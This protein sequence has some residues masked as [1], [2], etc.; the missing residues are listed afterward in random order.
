MFEA[1]EPRRLLSVVPSL[2]EI[3]ISAAAKA[4][5]PTLNN[6]RCFDLDVTV[7]AGGEDWASGD[8]KAVLTNG[9]F[10]NVPAANPLD[11][12]VAQKSLW[13]VRP[14]LEFDTFVTAPNFQPRWK[15]GSDPILNRTILLGSYQ[16][17]SQ[18]PIFTDTQVNASWGD[19]TRTGAGTFTVA[20]LTI[21]KDA[22]G[23]AQGRV[24]NITQPNDPTYYDSILPL[25]PSNTPPVAN[26][27]SYDTAQDTV[28][29]ILPPGMLTNDT[30]AD[31]DALTAVLAAGP[32]Y[33]TL[34]FDEDGSFIYQPATGFSGTDTFTY[35]ASDGTDASQ[36][37]TVTINVAPAAAGTITSG[38]I[39]PTDPDG[40]KTLLIVNGG[41]DNDAIQIESADGGGVQVSVNGQ[42]DPTV[43]NPTGRIVIFGYGGN[44]SISVDGSVANPVWAY[45]DDGNDTLNLGN[46]GG[47]AFGGA[48]GDTLLGGSAR[49]IL[50]GGLG[51]DRI[52]GNAGDDILISGYTAFDTRVGDRAGTAP[53]NA[54]ATLEHEPAWSSIAAES[55]SGHEYQ[56]RVDNLT[57]GAGDDRANGEHFLNASSSATSGQTVFDDGATDELDLV[58]GS[59]GEDWF[60]LGSAN[61]RVTGNTNGEVTTV[62]S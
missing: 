54:P 43:Y 40:A 50:V 44:D 24:G 15:G 26:D 10:Y 21:S 30:D 17:G 1:C 52:I 20:R 45:G 18:T 4:A 25:T 32:K 27:D 59:A 31:G 48:G 9:N 5:D 29:S 22:I 58:T 61:D 51:G 12:D 55:A 23:T 13:A 57:S 19:I 60:L 7:S 46:G 33:G 49:D 35:R 42:T 34:S 16:P 38:L 56:A 47:I 11:G 39:D 8:I 28:L 36:T 41:D 37:A 2:V 53:P 14:N 62:V 3:P 6:Y